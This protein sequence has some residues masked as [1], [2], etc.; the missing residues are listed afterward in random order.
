MCRATRLP[1]L[2]GLC[3]LVGVLAFL[4]R[5]SRAD[6]VVL[7]WEPGKGVV[8]G[9][10][11]YVQSGCIESPDLITPTLLA[12]SQHTFTMDIPLPTQDCWAV[13]AVDPAGRE[14]PSN[15]VAAFATEV[16]GLRLDVVSPP[17]LA[18]DPYVSGPEAT[19][20]F[21]VYRQPRCTGTPTLLT[22]K[23]LPAGVLRYVDS[24]ALPAGPGLMC[25][26]VAAVQA[27]GREAPYTLVVT[28]PPRPS[29]LHV[30]TDGQVQETVAPVP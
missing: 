30:V 15:T 24:R 6:P 14:I 11:V 16:A 9:W 18:W 29:N 21:R 22:K 26:I 13:A 5:L 3:V 25:W 1:A 19:T 4:P 10:K 23:L 28:L 12:A 7:S 2:V 17:T 8:I 27:D 20:G